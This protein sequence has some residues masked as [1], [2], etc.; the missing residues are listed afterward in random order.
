[1]EHEEADGD[2]AARDTRRTL[3]IG[4]AHGALL[5]KLGGL[6]SRS[7]TRQVEHMIAVA[8]RDAGLQGLMVELGIPVPPVGGAS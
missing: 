6:L 5:R 1:V 7:D 8:G 3:H 2:E 4:G